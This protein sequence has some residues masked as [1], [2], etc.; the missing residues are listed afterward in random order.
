MSQRHMRKDMLA[1]GTLMLEKDL[2]FYFAERHNVNYWD[3]KITY[4]HVE[5]NWLKAACL[6]GDAKE[7]DTVAVRLE[8]Y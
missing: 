4:I 6:I 8:I 2:K 5:N 7:I 3:I 1:T